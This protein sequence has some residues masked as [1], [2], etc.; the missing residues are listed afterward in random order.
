MQLLAHTETESLPS[1]LYRLCNLSHR[2]LCGHTSIE[3]GLGR[4]HTT[5]SILL[6]QGRGMRI[7]APVLLGA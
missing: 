5:G 6:S 4:K 2:T 3:G 7:F 1:P